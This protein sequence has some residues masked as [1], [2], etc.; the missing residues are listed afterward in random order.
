MGH[1]PAAHGDLT[2]ASL[3]R[4]IRRA[5]FQHG[6]T[7]AMNADERDDDDL[8]MSCY[9]DRLQ[10]QVRECA[11]IGPGRYDDKGVT[12]S[13]ISS[14]TNL[15]L[16]TSRHPKDVKDYLDSLPTR[17]HRRVWIN[18]KISCSR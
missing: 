6:R 1:P 9:Q 18:A 2:L 8:S 5:N 14:L 10:V 15:L 7:F 11:R 12:F 17:F 3:L 4:Q 13:M 16:S